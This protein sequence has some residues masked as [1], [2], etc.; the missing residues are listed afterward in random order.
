[1]TRRHDHIHTECQLHRIAIKDN[2]RAL[3]Q[4]EISKEVEVRKR[5]ALIKSI[6]WKFSA[7]K[8][9]RKSGFSAVNSLRP[10]QYAKEA[11]LSNEKL[12]V[13]F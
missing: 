9:K 1:M 11:S 6:P 5:K 2:H 8:Q 3:K 7:K 13:L 10:E 4:M 12:S